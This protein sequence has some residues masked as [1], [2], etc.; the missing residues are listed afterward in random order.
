M[1][2]KEFRD[3]FKQDLNDPASTII[4]IEEIRTTREE[5]KTEMNISI[6]MM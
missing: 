3:H 4:A 6:G 1:T 2:L 5:H